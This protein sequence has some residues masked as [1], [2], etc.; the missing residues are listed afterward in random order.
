V[1]GMQGAC[2]NTDTAC[3]T[4]LVAAHAAAT[5]VRD[6]ECESALTLA[7]NLMLLP[8]GHLLVAIAGMTSA[9]G[10]CK[11]LDSRANGYVR[12]EGVGAALLE[13]KREAAS[14]RGSA[15][16]SDGKSASLTA[17]N[18]EAQAGLL[19]AAMLLG[20][21]EAE[22]V[23]TTECHGTG[24]ALGDPIETTALRQVLMPSDDRDMLGGVKANVGHMEPSAGMV[25]LLKLDITLGCAMVAPNAQLR[26]LNP[27]VGGA[28][29]GAA[30]RLP[31]Q[32]SGMEKGCEHVRRAGGVSSFGYAGTIAHAV[33]AFS[34]RKV[35][36]ALAFGTGGSG[37]DSSEHQPLAFSRGADPD[38]PEVLAFGS[39]GAEVAGGGV[40]SAFD[41]RPA[42]A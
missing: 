6:A 3:S 19:R 26:V 5:M 2:Y 14:L 23:H 28:L 7:V 20:A 36:E 9:D 21:L 33:L 29:R 22:D 42:L 38:A 32:P 35:G 30:C 37:A 39:Q 40:C 16:R 31:T 27:H 25:G 4:A 18:G 12:S 1:L 8:L 10:R 17:P 24:T 13:P 15:V 11:F 34:P 41:P